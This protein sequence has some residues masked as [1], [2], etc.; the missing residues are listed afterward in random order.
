MGLQR[1]A[2]AG[3]VVEIL[4][5]VLDKGIVIDASVRVAVAGIEVLGIDARLVVASIETYLRHADAVASTGLATPLQLSGGPPPIG[6]GP[7]I[8]ATTPEPPEPPAPPLSPLEPLP[9]EPEPDP[10]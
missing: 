10:G 5:R 9:T 6:Q 7:Q 1:S 2:P 4:D 8:I 3:S